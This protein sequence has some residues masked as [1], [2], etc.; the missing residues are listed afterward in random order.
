MEES[1]YCFEQVDQMRGIFDAM[2]MI[3]LVSDEGCDM[4]DNPYILNDTHQYAGDID[5]LFL[6]CLERVFG[7]VETVWTNIEGGYEVC[8]LRI[9]FEKIGKMR[10]LLPSQQKKTYFQNLTQMLHVS[11]EDNFYFNEIEMEGEIS[12][13]FF[14][15]TITFGAGLFSPLLEEIMLMRRKVLETIH[16]QGLQMINNLRK[17][18]IAKMAEEFNIEVMFNEEHSWEKVYDKLNAH[19]NQASDKEGLIQ[20]EDEM[21]NF[22][23][24]LTEYKN[25]CAGNEEAA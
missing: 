22:M 15:L 6:N 12:G 13:K 18:V 10:L 4:K 1:Y 9:P 16:L 7:K 21:I 14:Y 8:K 25:R 24:K 11:M 3:K 19:V 17:L 20:F 5:G 23:S 2:V